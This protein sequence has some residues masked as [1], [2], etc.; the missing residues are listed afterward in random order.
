MGKDDKPVKN[1]VQMEAVTR[2]QGIAHLLV[3]PD[4]IALALHIYPDLFDVAA[5]AIRVAAADPAVSEREPVIESAK[6]AN[7][8]VANILQRYRQHL[9]ESSFWRETGLAKRQL[10]AIADAFI[11]AKADA[12]QRRDHTENRAAEAH[13]AKELDR[14]RNIRKRTRH[15]QRD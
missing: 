15:I 7:A 10:L 9:T 6:N 14:Q 8:T 3:H 4:R 5:T 2:V 1:E 11:A 12:A 13:R